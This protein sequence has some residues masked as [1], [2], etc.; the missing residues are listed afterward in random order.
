MQCSAVR[1]AVHDSPAAAAARVMLGACR[2][3]YS[4][5][6]EASNCAVWCDVRRYLEHRLLNGTSEDDRRSLEIPMSPVCL[7]VCET[8]LWSFMAS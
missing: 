6:L 2:R 8:Y 3:G 1:A 5:M 7:S 4:C